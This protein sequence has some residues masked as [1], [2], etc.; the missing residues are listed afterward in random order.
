MNNVN[1]I[2]VFVVICIVGF[3]IRRLWVGLIDLI[4]SLF[5]KLFFR[6]SDKNK[7]KWHSMEDIQSKNKK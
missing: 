5:K 7:T 6:N 3:V 2:I 4:I 1:Y